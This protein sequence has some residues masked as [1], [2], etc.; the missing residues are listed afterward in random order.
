MPKVDEAE[1]NT[2]MSEHFTDPK[3]IHQKA[4]KPKKHEKSE[5]HYRPVRTGREKTPKREPKPSLPVPT[6]NF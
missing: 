2:S 5:K 4:I 1:D 3:F 6:A